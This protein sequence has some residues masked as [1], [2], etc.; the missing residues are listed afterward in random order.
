MSIFIA[1]AG[2]VG[3]LVIFGITNWLLSLRRI[4]PT[5]EVHIVQS[6]KE[7]VVYGKDVAN[8]KG[9]SYYEFPEWIPSLG[10]SVTVLPASVFKLSL[11]NYEAYDKD[12]LPF[13]VDIVSFFRIENFS[14]ASSRVL[15]YDELREQLLGIVQGAVRSILAKEDLENIM[16]ERNKYGNMFTDEVASQLKEWGVESVKNI[17]LMDIRDLHGSE[18]IANIMKKKK[19]QIEME[20]RVTVAE[21]SRKAKEAEITA[22]QAVAL[23]QQDANRQVGLREAEVTQEVGIANEKSNQEIQAQAKITAEKEMEVEKVRTVQAAEIQKEADIVNANAN[24]QTITINAAAAVAKAEA[25]KQ[26]IV[27]N[28]EANKQKIELQADA[29][30]KVA[31]NTAKGVEAT[32]KANAEAE[33]LMKQAQVAGD[34]QLAEKIGELKEYQDFIVRQKQVEALCE[35]GK[36]QAKNLGNAE[37]KIFANSGSV[38]DGVNSAQNIFST[39]TGLNVA[40]LLESFVSTPMGAEIADKVLKTGDT[41]KAVETLKQGL[42]DFKNNKSNKTKTDE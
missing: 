41:V 3:L 19:S 22:E 35:V 4:V 28:A 5:N 14:L 9:N 42:K 2:V 21:N 15:S 20:S 18:V 13:V 17:E 31:T 23:A 32:G 36:E 25:D 12:R 16:S 27:F 38:A 7:T 33:K 30:L 11:D 10:V 40:S 8:G 1:G 6:S 34:I 26:V 37:I 29:D 39:N 24:K